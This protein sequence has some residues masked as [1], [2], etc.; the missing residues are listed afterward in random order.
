MRAEETKIDRNERDR[1]TISEQRWDPE[2]REALILKYAPL[3]HY[4]AS[5]IRSR[6]PSHVE[7]GD[8]VNAGIIG[9]IDA[10]N[11]FDPEKNIQFKTYAEY[12][13]RGAI[14][15]E[16]RAMDW[17][18]R[19]VRK[20]VH[21]LEDTF[22]RLEQKYKRPATDEEAASALGLDINSYHQLVANAKSIPLFNLDD[23]G[24][25]IDPK[26]VLFREDRDPSAN[27]WFKE[28][29][30]IMGKAIDILPDKERMVVTLYYYEELTMK[31]I[32]SVLGV[33]ESRVSQLHTKAIIRLRKK[34][35]REGDLS[36]GK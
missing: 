23:L 14:M 32:A 21:L 1:S 12:R 30:G 10:L 34:L 9:F 19:S 31:E 6:L 28:L 29:S 27:A 20:K 2:S 36:D 33:T 4:I 26:E 13:I 15:D 22:H 18:P 3:I 24:G 8:L 11:R 25:D 17:I 35:K 7:L 16:V 5:R